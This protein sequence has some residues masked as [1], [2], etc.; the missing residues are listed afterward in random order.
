MPGTLTAS[1]RRLRLHKRGSYMPP[2][3]WYADTA[4]AIGLRNAV[5]ERLRFF[6]AGDDTP[7]IAEF[8]VREYCPPA[9][10]ANATPASSLAPCGDWG[11]QPRR[12]ESS[13][14]PCFAEFNTE[15]IA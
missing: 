2:V 15:A 9:A 5:P 11:V 8:T 10:H 3:R 6:I 13:P 4:L 1:R 14:A 12:Y 7:A